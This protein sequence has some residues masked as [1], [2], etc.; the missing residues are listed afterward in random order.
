MNDLETQI[1]KACHEADENFHDSGATGTKTWIRDFFL[2]ALKKHDLV[3][4]TL[5]FKRILEF[6]AKAMAHAADTHVEEANQ[7]RQEIK[8]LREYGNKDCTTMADD[9]LARRRSLIPPRAPRGQR[10]CNKAVRS[11]KQCVCMVIY[12]CPDH[13]EEHIGTHD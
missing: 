12:E 13:G 2:P 11:K 4:M 1:Y 7:L 8:V 5:E 3:I 10:C 9:E 6:N